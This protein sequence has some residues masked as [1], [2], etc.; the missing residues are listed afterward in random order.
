MSREQSLRSGAGL[1]VLAALLFLVYAIAFFF[2][3]FAGSGFACRSGPLAQGYRVVK[4]GT[5]LNQSKF[6]CAPLAQQSSRASACG[7]RSPARAFP[8]IRSIPARERT[9]TRAHR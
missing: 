9:P 3:A 4:S 8:P 1:M 6:R 2:R 7:C 5:N